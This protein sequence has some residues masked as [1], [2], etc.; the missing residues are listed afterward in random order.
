MSQYKTQL[1]RKRKVM[2]DLIEPKRQFWELPEYKLEFGDPKKNKAV[3]KHRMIKGK[4]V[5]GEALRGTRDVNKS[6]DRLGESLV[7]EIGDA[8]S[9]CCTCWLSSSGNLLGK[10]EIA[11]F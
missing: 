10:P 11:S 7:L 2:D 6:G 1:T 8:K 3:V 5:A 9:F 4:K